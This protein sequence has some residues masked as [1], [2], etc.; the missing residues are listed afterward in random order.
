[1]GLPGA[2]ELGLEEKLR[3]RNSLLKI[4]SARGG[5]ASGAL[6]SI[7]PFALS[8][9]A[10]GCRG[11]FPRTVVRDSRDGL[12]AKA[13][14]Q[15]ALQLIHPTPEL[16]ALEAGAVREVTHNQSV[17][18]RLHPDTNGSP[19]TFEGQFVDTRTVQIGLR[20][21]LTHGREHS[22]CTWTVESETGCIR[23]GDFDVTR[24]PIVASR[25]REG[26]PAQN[27]QVR[28]A[29]H[30]PFCPFNAAAP[31]RDFLPGEVPAPPTPASRISPPR[32]IDPRQVSA[33]GA[34]WVAA[35]DT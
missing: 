14:A 13:L 5:S 6:V 15:Q 11:G 7:L 21:I 30:E 20:G 34:R 29:G 35:K 28:A 2:I 3:C 32:A 10:V 31:D 17:F 27:H 4:G 26:H 8:A 12:A 24:K 19:A 1:M 33:R 23:P 25:Q 22:L 9:G 16:T 18:R